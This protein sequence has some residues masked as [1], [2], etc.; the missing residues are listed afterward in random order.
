MY[1]QYLLKSLHNPIKPQQIEHNNK[2]K[3]NNLNDKANGIIINY[4]GKTIVIKQPTIKDVQILYQA[5]MANKKIINNIFKI[6][7]R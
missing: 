3:Q 6:N 5:I 4:L 7:W 2:N 1:K